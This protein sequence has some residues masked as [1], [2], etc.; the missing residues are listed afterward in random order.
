MGGAVLSGAT[1]AYYLK[2]SNPG[3]RQ[4]AVSKGVWFS[5]GLPFRPFYWLYCKFSKKEDERL[6][7]FPRSMLKKDS[8]KEKKED[9]PIVYEVRSA[10]KQAMPKVGKKSAWIKYFISAKFIQNKHVLDTKVEEFSKYPHAWVK[11]DAIFG[12]DVKKDDKVL[13][14]KFDKGKGNT[15]VWTKI[16]YKKEGGDVQDKHTDY[17]DYG[18]FN[19]IG[20]F[21]TCGK[22]LLGIQLP[23]PANWTE[24]KKE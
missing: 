22:R 9:D 23:P 19:P 20:W 5:V 8:G 13:V 24:K 14:S 3:D 1:L 6:L 7:L 2:G 10:I 18:K 15:Y 12:L 16:E 21:V 4:S 11:N 17:V